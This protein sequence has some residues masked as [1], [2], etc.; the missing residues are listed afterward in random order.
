MKFARQR[1]CHRPGFAVADRTRVDFDDGN[2]FGI[3]GSLKAAHGLATID[4]EPVDLG[5]YAG[6][7]ATALNIRGDGDCIV[8]RAR[9]RPFDEAPLQDQ[10]CR[11]AA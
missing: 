1:F 7:S 9:P 11:G 2:D 3:I 10:L 5:K 6:L 4:P 8:V